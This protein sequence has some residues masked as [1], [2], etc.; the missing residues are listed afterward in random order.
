[1]WLLLLALSCVFC[2]VLSGSFV[3]SSTSLADSSATVSNRYNSINQSIDQY[4]S[5]SS[6]AS[7]ANDAGLVVGRQ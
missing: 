3:V 5:A 2:C 4:I 1:M 6:Q 7:V